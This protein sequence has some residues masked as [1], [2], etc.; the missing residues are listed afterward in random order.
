MGQYFDNDPSLKHVDLH[1]SFYLFGKEFTL[2]SDCGVFSKDGL[3]FGSKLLLETICN[4]DLG[5]KILDLGCGVGPI[6]LILAHASCTRKVTLVD[7]NLR[8]LEACQINSET[9]GVASQVE[10]FYSDIYSNI[11]TSFSSIVT[12]PPIRAGKE[13]TY[14]I[15]AGARDHLLNNGK[16][17][18]VIRKQQGALS[19][20]KYLE[21]IYSKVEILERKKGYYILAATK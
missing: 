15:Y 3:D 1:Y 17:Y 6:G 4:L 19:A 16:L 10:I 2:K 9:L 5:D 18:L 13:V 8:A 14:S 20:L 11:S 21:S 12:N 7:V